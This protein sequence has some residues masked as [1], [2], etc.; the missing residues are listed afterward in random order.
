MKYKAKDM[1]DFL[2]EIEDL[3]K[4]K[5]THCVED[6]LLFI[7]EALLNGDDVELRNIG[8]LKIVNRPQRKIR[9]FNIKENKVIEKVV[10]ARKVL[11]L[12]VSS[13]I[14]KE[15]VGESGGGNE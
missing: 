1:I 2:R 14:K 13:I 9:A 5:A 12:R 4:V 11:K 8:V 10:P 15:L 3:D 7:R 6:I